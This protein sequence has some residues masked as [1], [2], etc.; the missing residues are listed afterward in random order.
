MSLA[1]GTRLGPYEILAQ[2][3]A[4]GMGEVYRARD[5]RLERTVAVKVLPTHLA[6]SLEVRQRFER[7]AKAI[8]QLSHPHICALYDVGREGETEY[9]VMELLEGETLSDRLAKGPLPLEQTLR[10]GT[11]IADALDKAHRQ[12]IAHRDLKPGNVMLTKSGVKLLDFGLAK[13]MAQAQPQSG[14]TSD[15][16]MA[17]APNVTREG[18]ILGT[19]Q[20]MAPEQLEGKEADGRT[21]IFAFG[22]V[23]YEMATGKKAFP[24]S[25]QASLISSIMTA[26]PPA[27]STVEPRTPPLFEHIVQRCLAK[28]PDDR[29][30]SASD[31]SGELRWLAST[32]S[33][34][35]PAVSVR[36]SNGRVIAI[37]A[38]LLLAALLAA[39]ALPRLRPGASHPQAVRFLIAPP[40]GGLFTHDV[41]ATN[42][43]ISP[44]GRHLAFVA[45][46]Q[47][48]RQIWLRDLDRVSARPLEGTG[49]GSSP[50]WSPDSRSLGFFADRKLKRLAI[51]GGVPQA[52]TEAVNGGNACWGP[53]DTILFIDNV[54]REGILRVPA[55]GGAV[56][57]VTHFDKKRGDFY[58]AW[59]SFL[60]DG[61]HFLYSVWF[62]TEGS[63]RLGSLEQ[64]DLGE[65]LPV[66][67]RALFASDGYLLYVSEGALLARP[68][69]PKGLR[70][71]G[72]PFT[73]AGRVPYF[74]ITGGA[75]FAVSQTGALAFV[76][77][78]PQG[79]MA[80]FDRGGREVGTVGESRNL[81]TLS[82]SPE[83]RRV[84]VGIADSKVG[85]IHLWI[86]DLGGQP[87][88]RFS[89]SAGA[90]FAPV[91]SP[92]GRHIVFAQDPGNGSV[93]LRLKEVGDTG[94]GEDLLAPTNFQI[95]HDWSRD[96]RFIVYTDDDPKTHNDI[97]IL[98]VTGDRKP[99]PFLRTSFEESDA[100]MSPDG[101]SIAYVSDESGRSEV[102]V[103]SF[104]TGAGRRRVSVE[105]GSQ[106]RWRKDGRELFFLAADA[107]LMAVPVRVGEPMDLGAPVPLFRSP[108]T[109]S[110]RSEL[111]IWNDYDVSPDGQ[112]FLIRVDL[113][114]R[115][116]MPMTVALGWAAGIAR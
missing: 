65:L 80:W 8:S 21:D 94:G 100:R 41:V 92:D 111:A 79:R 84:A 110:N 27:I 46:S 9:L 10:Y 90:E 98:P 96:G 36:S 35:L 89:F 60:P 77:G 40:A 24:G 78:E 59:P 62:K 73:V 17:G 23:L 34:G 85:S 57:G 112:R 52:I 15:P 3:G 58:H 113:I 43:A 115:D 33:A 71:W 44:D 31:V 19:F 99:I 102:Y 1:P 116:T 2:I 20:Y 76:E 42:M 63:I 75:D 18:T 61:R 32:P 13:V 70:L 49:G 47:G 14:L 55:G 64:G 30:Q 68:F 5:T 56:V 97:W 83:G 22:A 37:V 82:I 93:R 29:W 28:G 16:T 108:T 88:L 54:G 25:S 72:D 69:D 53:D 103:A 51:S 38:L 74:A 66:P 107:R 106:P 50:F 87:P 12:G 81:E 39:F 4:G 109:A 7:E 95:P 101:R 26:E 105:G 48:R 67:S 6:S 114:S 104:P 91:W 11:E 86:E 45:S